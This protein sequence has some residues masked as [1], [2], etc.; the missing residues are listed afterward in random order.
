MKT[1]L[2]KIGDKVEVY[3]SEKKLCG[4][5][6]DIRN[7]FND[8]YYQIYTNY[9]EHIDVSIYERI[10]YKILD[11]GESVEI[12]ETYALK[13]L[14]EFKPLHDH[15]NCLFLLLIRA[16]NK[17]DLSILHELQHR[18]DTELKKAIIDLIENRG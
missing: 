10:S 11:S 3:Y 5:I 18:A 8:K 6:Y 15:H 17:Y 9:L 7:V 16:T 14:L 13:K 1:T 12:K 2:Y 4:V